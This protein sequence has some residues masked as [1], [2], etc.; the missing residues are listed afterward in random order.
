MDNTDIMQ[1]NHTTI[2]ELAQLI[3]QANNDA[4]EETYL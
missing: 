3:S 1:A 4:V 2:S